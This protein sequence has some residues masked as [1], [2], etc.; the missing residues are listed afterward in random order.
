MFNQSIVLDPSQ[1]GEQPSRISLEQR[2]LPVSLPNLQAEH[3]GCH[4]GIEEP[5]RGPDLRPTAGKAGHVFGAF[6]QGMLGLQLF[7]SN[8]W[9]FRI[10]PLKVKLLAGEQEA[11]E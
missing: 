7:L 4:R 10:K 9:V 6:C 1:P 3:A 5:G 11:T 2:A 8:E